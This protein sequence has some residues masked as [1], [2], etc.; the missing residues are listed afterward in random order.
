MGKANSFCNKQRKGGKSHLRREGTGRDRPAERQAQKTLTLQHMV[1]R[2]KGHEDRG[3]KN[4]RPKK[5]ERSS[6][7]IPGIEK[8]GRGKVMHTLSRVNSKGATLFCKRKTTQLGERAKTS[9][10]PYRAKKLQ[11]KKDGKRQ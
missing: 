9:S 10:T 2:G 7:G 8:D 3:K 5:G 4:H 1:Y 11:E 6:K